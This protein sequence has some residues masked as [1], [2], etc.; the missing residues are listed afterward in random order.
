MRITRFPVNTFKKYF[1]LVFI[2]TGISLQAQ[3]DTVRINK[4][5]A[6]KPI[7][8]VFKEIEKEHPVKFFYKTEWLK[9][10]MINERFENMPL[11]QVLDKILV[12]KPYIY[13]VVRDRMI[14][15]LPKEEVEVFMATNFNNPGKIEE[16]INTRLIGDPNEAGKYKKV[17]LHGKVVDGKNNEPLIG[18]TIQIK[19]TRQGVVT[20]L[21]GNYK[22][23]L[24]PGFYTIVFSSIGFEPK[25]QQVK[26]ISNGSL[27]IKLFEKS[28]NIDEISIYAKRANRNVN[29]NQMSLIEMDARTIQE[30]PAIT[31]EKDVLKGLTLMPGVKA[32]G[33]FGSGIHV[34]GGGDDQNLF[35]LN[36]APL[37][38][39]SHVF[40]LI[41]VINPD[42]VSGLT[43]YKGHIPAAYG[44]RASSVVN[45]RMN[46]VNPDKFST[47]GGI[48][49]YNARLMIETPLFNKKLSIRLGG[50]TSYSDWLLNR[51][52]DYYL[53]NSSAFFHDISGLA[54]LNFKKDH[55]IASWYNSYDHFTFASDFSYQYANSL[56]SLKWSHVFNNGIVST[57]NGAY[58]NYNVDRDEIK[59]VFY[60]SRINTGIT[61]KSAKANFSYNGFGRHE[62]DWGM[63]VIRYDVFPGNR[64]PISEESLIK[65]L[66]IENEQ[67]MESAVYASDVFD[68]T[69]DISL[70]LGLRYSRFDYLGPGKTYSY[71]NPEP[72]EIDIS[73][74]THHTENELVTRYQ[75]FEPRASLKI[76]VGRNNS[77]K[78]SYNRNLQYIS[79]ISHTSIST[80]GDIWKL[81]D[82]YLK[83]ITVNQYATGYYHNFLDNKL[84]TS[85]EFYYK[86]LTNL[87]EYR[88]NAQITLNDHIETELINAI[89]KSYGMEF[90]VRKN[91]GKY[92]GWIS[93]TY[94]RSF[95]KTNG[96]MSETSINENT[97]YPSNYDK[98]H[99]LTMVLNYNVNKRV[100]LSTN[101]SFASGRPVTL[102][103][104]QYKF[105]RNRIVYYSDR[106]KYRLPPYH[107]LDISLTIDESLRKNKK[108]KG[109]WTFSVLNVYGR[110]NAYTVFYKKE[111]PTYTN[112]YRWFSMYKMYI[113]GR[114]LPTL[115]YSFKF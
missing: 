31:G 58:S 111:D 79:L 29:L 11:P 80:P 16:D 7:I 76:Q 81:S 85:V 45:I 83:P 71:T 93:Y 65:P 82:P 91:A 48:G 115:T 24:S 50:R 102:P 6:G 53:K 17:N 59:N 113:I 23:Q 114:P 1:L 96:N 84:E 51:M 22:L 92:T 77:V 67:G 56:G 106:N 37:M 36:G 35:L 95:A 104:Y 28:V 33:E 74:T 78:V 9:D 41:S 27:D 94:S 14:I 99:D 61:Y 25:E 105:G 30:L 44:E 32:V 12:D 13:H 21:D 54:K 63:K 39:T 112:D 109:S 73:D 110:N 18:A 60:K 90:F 72:R 8:S 86:D 75:G 64:V 70:N 68:L 46:E 52:N 2:V 98:P 10:Y 43:L 38:N 97:F 62:F 4:K 55:F 5:F 40:G 89:G 107:R 88:N 100:R 66:K 69:T 87:H 19:G 3:I 103:E 42:V 108:W 49:L 57:I 34:R 15:L 26:I 47:S 101:F 20:G